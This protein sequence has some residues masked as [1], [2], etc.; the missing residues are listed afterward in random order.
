MTDY[1]RLFCE[2]GFATELILSTQRGTSSETFRKSNPNDPSNNLLR[3]NLNVEVFWDG[4][5]P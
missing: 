2:V 4:K 1:F 3:K 5:S